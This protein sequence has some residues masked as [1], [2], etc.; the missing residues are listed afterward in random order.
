MAAGSADRLWLGCAPRKSSLPTCR[1]S[2]LTYQGRAIKLSPAGTVRTGAGEDSRVHLSMQDFQSWTGLQPSLVEIA[3]YGSPGEVSSLLSILRRDLPEVDVH[4]VRQV[5][6]G[7]REH[8]R[9]DSLNTAVVGGF[10]CLY[11]GVMCAGH[12]YGMDF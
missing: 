7:R 1:G 8:F 12:S 11:C 2:T 6:E 9:E 3:A 4:P 10:H 5:T